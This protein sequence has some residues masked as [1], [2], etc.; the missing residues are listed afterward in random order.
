M[1]GEHQWQHLS[2]GRSARCPCSCCAAGS[3][4]GSCGAGPRRSGRS[5]LRA[6]R[7]TGGQAGCTCESSARGVLWAAPGPRLQEGTKIG[8]WTASQLVFLSLLCRKGVLRA[9]LGWFT[10][11]TQTSEGKDW[12][13]DK[14]LLMVLS[15]GLKTVHHSLGKRTP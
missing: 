10:I 6:G 9:P 4:W 14:A 3:P 13:Q 7:W 5:A 15:F 12:L 11:H 8:E 1:P 2:S